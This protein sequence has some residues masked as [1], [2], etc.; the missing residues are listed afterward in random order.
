MME[1]ET[2]NPCVTSI[3]LFGGPLCRGGVSA[4]DAWRKLS[5]RYVAHILS[6]NS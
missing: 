4:H 6:L 1:L 2:V 5:M 3:A